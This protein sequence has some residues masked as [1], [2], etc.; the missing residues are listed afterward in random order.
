[1]SLNEAIQEAIRKSLPGEFATELQAFILQARKDGVELETLRK[2][3]A[4]NALTEVSLR[5]HLAAAESDL[6]SWRT[7][8]GALL[9][10]ESKVLEMEH[11]LEIA[12]IRVAHAEDKVEF[13][14]VLVNSVFRNTL[15]RES[16]FKNE[17]IQDFAPVY[18][19]TGI[20]GYAPSG[21]HFE[22]RSEVVD[23]SAE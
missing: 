20:S 15:V 23:K 11:R 5:E 9:E 10:R 3:A 18:G 21:H 8:E 6:A 1:M 2:R 16:V 4:E 13:A 19:S 7:R 22:G 14:K 17:K 12:G